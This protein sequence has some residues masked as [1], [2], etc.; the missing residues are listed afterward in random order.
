[1]YTGYNDK[2]ISNGVVL[3]FEDIEHKNN[4]GSSGEL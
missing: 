3:D 2:L 4:M 1:M